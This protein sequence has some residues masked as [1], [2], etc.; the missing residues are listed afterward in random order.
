M[1]IPISQIQ[2]HAHKKTIIQ[3]HF[4]LCQKKRERQ[5]HIEKKERERERER[6]RRERERERER[7]RW[8]ET[9]SQECVK[10]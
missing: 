7:E 1:G 3:I 4:Q 9:D 6:E 2:I 5:R 8:I 10:L